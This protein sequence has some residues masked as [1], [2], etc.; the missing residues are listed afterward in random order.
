MPVRLPLTT[1]PGRSQR[2]NAAPQTVL[3]SL[4]G[5]PGSCRQWN[6]G[7]H[8]G[9]QHDTCASVP[10]L[11]PRPESRLHGLCRA[12]APNQSLLVPGLGAPILIHLKSEGRRRPLPTWSRGTRWASPERRSGSAFPERKGPVK[13]VCAGCRRLSESPTMN[14]PILPLRARD[15]RL[16]RLAAPGPRSLPLQ[17][18]GWPLGPHPLAVPLAGLSHSRGCPHPWAS[19][20][21][22]AFPQSSGLGGE[23]GATRP[24]WLG[25]RNHSFP[26]QPGVTRVSPPLTGGHFRV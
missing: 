7:A 10:P 17:Q 25:P 6:P 26:P 11:T 12:A 9:G 14:I 13:H 4:P 23:T 16:S 20:H 19:R 1:Q 15:P 21:G 18:S 2:I 3:G 8:S 5:L 22:A 24:W